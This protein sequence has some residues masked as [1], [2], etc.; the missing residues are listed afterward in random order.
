MDNRRFELLKFNY[1][2][3]H[4]AVWEA[5]KVAWTVIDIFI[6]VIF[7]L[8]G[9][10]A[11]EYVPA[12]KHSIG[13][14]VVGVL[15][16]ESLLLIWRVIMLMLQDYNRRRV[17]KLEGIEEA[18]VDEFEKAGGSKCRRHLVQQYKNFSYRFYIPLTKIRVSPGKIYNSIAIL[19]TAVNISF[20]TYRI[21][22][23][24]GLKFAAFPVIAFGATAIG[25][26]YRKRRWRMKRR[27]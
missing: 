25:I 10:L 8:Q 16:L 11:K 20:I 1:G 5:H 21:V 13:E 19:I 17:E 18:L 12:G 24:G 4:A 2:N 7:A 3:L 9:Y 23:W 14:L 15:L 27:T 6:P 26:R 22:I